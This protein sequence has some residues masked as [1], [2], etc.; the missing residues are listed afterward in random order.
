MRIFRHP[1]GCVR[2]FEPTFLKTLEEVG[3]VMFSSKLYI[4]EKH[5]TLTP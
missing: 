4:K 1:I 3:I 2:V 5:T